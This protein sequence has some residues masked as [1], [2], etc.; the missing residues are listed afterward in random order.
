M[1]TDCEDLYLSQMGVEIRDSYAKLRRQAALCDFC[2]MR[3]S[4]GKDSFDET[5]RQIVFQLRDSDLH[6]N[7]KPVINFLASPKDSG[8]T[9][10]FSTISPEVSVSITSS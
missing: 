7:G 3:W 4:L 8:M 9:V 5:T 10:I 6:L 1:C 2:K